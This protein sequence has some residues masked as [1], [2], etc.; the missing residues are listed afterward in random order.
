MEEIAEQRGLT[1]NTIQ[2]HFVK[3]YNEGVNIDLTNFVSEK[4]IE[5]V[6]EA[7]EKIEN[8]KSLKSY[9]EYFNEQIDY[10]AIKMA[11]VYLENEEK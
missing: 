5:A 7:Q 3:L 2:S 6:K 9:Y 4:E 1:P 8:P 10:A 11:L